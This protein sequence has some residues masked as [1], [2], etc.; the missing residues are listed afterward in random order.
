MNRTKLTPRQLQHVDAAIW[1]ALDP[2]GAPIRLAEIVDNARGYIPDGVLAVATWDFY[3]I[4]SDGMQRMKHAGRV[5]LQK[6]RGGG[7]RRI[8]RPS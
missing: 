3:S 1:E 4:I 5:E 8:A 2:N 7:W 6:G